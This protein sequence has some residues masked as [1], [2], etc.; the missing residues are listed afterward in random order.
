LPF[1]AC[2][3]AGRD[4]GGVCGAPGG[5][6]RQAGVRGRRR[7]RSLLRRLQ[8]RWEGCRRAAQASDF[9]AWRAEPGPE[10]VHG[11]QPR[12]RS[13]NAESESGSR[14]WRH[15]PSVYAGPCLALP[16]HTAARRDIA[17]EL[18][19]LKLKAVARCRDH[20]MDRIYDMRRPKT[21]LQA[22]QAGSRGPL[23]CA[24]AAAARGSQPGLVCAAGGLRAGGSAC[25]QSRGG[26]H[27]GPILDPASA[28]ADQAERAAQVSLPG[29][30]P[31]PP[32]PRHL[33]RGGAWGAAACRPRRCHTPHPS[34]AYAPPMRPHFA[35]LPC[36]PGLRPTLRPTLCLPLCAPRCEL[37]TWRRW[38]E[39]CW[40]C[41]E[42]TG[43]PWKG[44]RCGGPCLAH[45]LLVVE[46]LLKERRA[47]WADGIGGISR[48]HALGAVG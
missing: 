7:H 3:A 32:R 35:T 31:A 39:R 37:R 44:W 43:P 13:T 14:G 2:P 36:H 8:A 15:V 29:C 24:A 11:G 10:G 12:S 9:T 5:A 38:G 30:L 17:P 40:T 42:P 48:A 20:L 27:P 34:D 25:M 19:R 46:V 16:Y 47:G 18:E 1:A 4:E 33:C 45:A 28:A 22:R 6:G 26:V 23:L 21:N 41:S